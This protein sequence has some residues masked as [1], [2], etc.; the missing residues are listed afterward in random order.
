MTKIYLAS[1]SPRRQELLTLMGLPYTLLLKEVNESYPQNLALNE[2]AAYLSVIKAKAFEPQADGII[3]TADTIVIINNQILGKP[4]NAQHAFDMLKKLSGN[5]HQVITAF[6]IVHNAQI[7]T[8]SDTTEVYFKILTNQQILDYINNFKPYDKAG[9]YGIQ[10]WMGLVAIEKIIG[11]YSNVM[12][13]PTQ[14]LYSV[15][16][17]MGLL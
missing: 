2:V 8:Y 7:Y 5:M 14:K 17:Q 1:K 11:S 9:A 10:E 13:L 12:G 6:S 3:L 4:T 15:L 16:Q